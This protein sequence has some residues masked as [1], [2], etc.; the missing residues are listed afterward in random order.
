MAMG[1]RDKSNLS[2]IYSTHKK[3]INKLKELIQSYNLTQKD[4]LNLLKI[5][6]EIPISIFNK[7]IS[8]L[9]TIT[10]YMKEELNLSYNEIAKELGR[11]ERNIW[12]SYNNAIKKHAGKLEIDSQK[13]KIP[14]LLFK[15]KKLSILETIVV[16]LKDNLN[17]NFSEI[18]K[19]MERNYR[20]IWTIYQRAIKK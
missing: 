1:T 10:K 18:S 6:Q 19:I 17:F 8:P 7:R 2:R 16:Y 4:T 15:E 20:T 3:E 11:D 12:H 14:C 13:G 9:E 5:N